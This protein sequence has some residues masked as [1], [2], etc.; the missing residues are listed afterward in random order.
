[1]QVWLPTLE[2]SINLPHVSRDAQRAFRSWKDE[3]AVWLLPELSEAVRWQQQGLRCLAIPAEHFDRIDIAHIDAEGRLSAPTAT[4]LP[5][6]IDGLLGSWLNTVRSGQVEMV[7]PLK[8]RLVKTPVFD[9]NPPRWAERKVVFGPGPLMPIHSFAATESEVILAWPPEGSPL[10]I[11][12]EAESAER[13]ALTVAADN[14]DEA[15]TSDGKRARRVFLKW[16][17]PLDGLMSLL[18]GSDDLLAQQLM[19]QLSRQALK[20]HSAVLIRAS[21]LAA[22]WIFPGDSTLELAWLHP[23]LIAGVGHVLLKAEEQGLTIPAALR[24]EPWDQALLD[25]LLDIEEWQRVL[26]RRDAIG[27]VWGAVGLFWSLLLDEIERKSTSFCERCGRLIS[28]KRGKRFCS[29]SDDGNCA[30][31]RRAAYK[32]KSRT[33]N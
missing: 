16:P 12:P 25:K 28:G 20:E 27:R 7:Q 10:A 8:E 29:G 18:S 26:G 21:E 6:T 1:L 32:R 30:R 24:D 23:A 5:T 17:K 33:K 31:A 13:F 14:P 19:E 4:W 11:S 22:P 2:D 15:V 9:S 3:V